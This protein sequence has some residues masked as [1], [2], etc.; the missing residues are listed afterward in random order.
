[1]KTAV[2]EIQVRSVL[3]KSGIPGMK[4]CINPYV[5]CAHACR[6]CYATFMKRFTGHIEPW[7]SFVDIKINAP[8]VLRRQLRRAERGTVMISSVTDPYQPVEAR[9]GLT[10]KCLEILS[11][12]KFPVSILTKSP[13]V[14]R[15]IDII[16]KL[17][18]TE[19]G[20]TI[21]TDDERIRKIFEP[22]APPIPA[23]IDA[24]K[25]LHK[26]GIEPYVFIGP[27]LPMDPELLARQLKPY[28]KSFLIDSMNY[29]SKTEWLYKK[30]KL[31][32]WL[33]AGFIDDIIS[34]LRKHLSTKDI[35]VIC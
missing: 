23:R 34:R 15:D 17:E 6:Y 13:L 5:G 7:G 22:S 11:L 20:L 24:L 4:Y 26:A 12:F 8:E 21:T 31:E 27:L 3:S 2:N 14:L 32:I 10:R 33:D 19:V 1:M 16:S 29:V 9:Y 30:S 28:A 25:K 18:D 35:S